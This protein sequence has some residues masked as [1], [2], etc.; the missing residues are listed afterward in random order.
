MQPGPAL[1]LPDTSIF[2][3][4]VRDDALAEWVRVTY[5][6]DDPA[7]SLIISVVNEGELRSLALQFGWGHRRLERLERLLAQAVVVPL[8]YPGIIESYA[9]I[10]AHCR[11]MGTPIGENDAWIAATARAAGA[12]LLT[13]DRDFDPIHPTF[14]N[15]DWID[16]TQHR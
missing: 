3:H 2:V 5:R 15:R 4:Y 12:R 13:T 11:K 6:F 9:R 16:P 7:T 8:D 10:D 14:V 1:Y